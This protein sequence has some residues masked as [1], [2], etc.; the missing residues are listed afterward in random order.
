M[1]EAWKRRIF[2][3]VA[4][5]IAGTA[6]GVVSFSDMGEDLVYYWSP[7]EL[8]ARSDAT[9]HIVRLG[10]QVEPGS[11]DWD[12]DAQTVVFTL[13]DGESSVPVF[14][15][16]NPPQ[17]FRDNIGV[18]VEGSLDAKGVFNTD[19]IMVKHSN[20]YQ[21]PEEGADMASISQTLEQ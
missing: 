17:M 4:L 7:T 15:T 9:N 1:T 21:A 2:A 5:T 6:L 12:K 3:L 20:E 16:G 11:I 13:S 19:K 14:S 8:L 10:G 18:V